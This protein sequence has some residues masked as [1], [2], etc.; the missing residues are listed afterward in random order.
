MIKQ[1]GKRDFR[2]SIQ[3]QFLRSHDRPEQSQLLLLLWPFHVFG[4]Y[5]CLPCFLFYVHWCRFSFPFLFST[6]I[7]TAP[8][9]FVIEPLFNS[10]RPSFRKTVSPFLSFYCSFFLFFL[11]LCNLPSFLVVYIPSPS[12]Q[13]WSVCN[14]WVS[15]N[16]EH[17]SLRD[18]TKGS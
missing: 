8:W 18:N 15:F 12:L 3:K 5:G 16:L 13:I 7:S 4:L 14:N 17:N 11:C 6:F 2:L 1:A 9:W 10:I